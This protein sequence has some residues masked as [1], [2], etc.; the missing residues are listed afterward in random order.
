MYF[1]RMMKVI[2]PKKS[3]GQHFLNDK[4]IAARIVTC[5]SPAIHSPGQ[6]TDTKRGCFNKTVGIIA[7]WRLA[8]VQPHFFTLHELDIV[9]AHSLSKVTSF[10]TFEAMITSELQNIKCIGQKTMEKLLQEFQ[11]VARIKSATMEELEK[12]AGKQKATVLKEF[13]AHS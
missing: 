12:I 2:K 13:F 1:C 10:N 7:S 4:N 9:S 11:S 8:G 3:L 5:H 6:V